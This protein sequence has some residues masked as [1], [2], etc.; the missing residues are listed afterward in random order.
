[1]PAGDWTDELRAERVKTA[2]DRLKK[3]LRSGSN[4]PS[5]YYSLGAMYMWSE[6]YA[7]ALTHFDEQIQAKLPRNRPGD[8]AFGMAGSAAWCLGDEKLAIKYWQKGTTP[9]YAVG[10][11]NTRTSLLLYAASVLKPDT[12]ATASA[13]KLLRKKADHWRVKNW[14]G[15]IAQFVLGTASEQEVRH[16]AVFREGDPIEPSPRSWQ[17]DFYKT[18]Q[19]ATSASTEL[20]ALESEFRN[21]LNVKRSEYLAGSKFFYFLRIE[22][23]YLLRNWLSGRSDA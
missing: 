6:D 21:L 3:E 14:P 23:F 7:S 19:T 2:L 22:E 11:A 20:R 4:Y 15:P 5:D 16:K 12:F 8:L 13:E 17:F 1:M 18:L 10:G 9:G